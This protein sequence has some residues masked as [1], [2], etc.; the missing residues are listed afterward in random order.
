MVAAALA[1]AALAFALPGG[2]PAPVGFGT[3]CAATVALAILGGIDDIRPLGASVR[4]ALQVGA[5]ALVVGATDPGRILPGPVPLALERCLVVLAGA[6]WVN[7]VN[8][9][10]GIDW[11]T[12][13]EIVPLTGTVAV[14]SLAGLVPAGAGAIAAA[15][16]GALLGFAPANRPVAR[17][18]LG[19]VG[20]LPIG[21]LTGFLLLAV[22]GAGHLAAALLL[23]LYY[24]ADATLTLA[25]RALRRERVWEAHR[26]HFY[27]R[28]RDN[29]FS[30]LA[31]DGH[32]LGLNLALAAL[33]AV[34][35][36]WPAA[37]GP[38]LAGGAALVALVLRRF[39]RPRSP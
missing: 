1:A 36:R 21:L 31:I 3:L 9:M 16:C 5:V 30:V 28:A 26:T 35:I 7:L 15:L 12:V 32:V 37:S 14:L 13:A 34:T 25:R 11:I 29:G 33:A 39:A 22:A 4:L 27:Q 8:F 18:F 6:W 38:A 19:D 23:A 10:D 20:S 24:L 2:A 17:L